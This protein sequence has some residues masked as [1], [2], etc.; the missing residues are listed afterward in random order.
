MEGDVLM[1]DREALRVGLVGCGFHGSAL[2]QAIVRTDLLRL[3]ACAD[4]DEAAAGRAAA[5]APEVST[6]NSV[7]ALLAE[8]D[9]DAVVVA[10]PHHLLAPVALAALSAGKHVLA[11]KPMALSEPEAVQIEIAAAN[12][13]VCYMAGYSFRFSMASYVRDLLAA[14]VAGEI[15]AITGS[16]GMGPMNHG[17]VALPETGGGPLFY[18]GCHLI[19][20]ILWFLADEPV[21]LYADV[22]R[23]AD[24]GT[25]ETSAI[26]IRF[27]NGAIAQCLVTQAASTFSYELEIHGRTGKIALRGRNFLQF[28]IEVSSNTVQA[29]REPTTIHPGVR[30]DNISMMLV[31][32]LEEFARSIQERRPPAITA[33]DGRRVLQVLDAVVESGRSGRP[34]TLSHPTSPAW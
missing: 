16:I 28:E 23:R 3:V 33:S 22:R 12:A 7:E 5:L 32:E 31:P 8:S 10:T 19:D 1:V 18:V 6:H 30:R 9:L 26:Q 14:G 29:Y 17:W 13:G 34:V 4:P 25:D 27:A 2:A 20:L 15:Q 21:G 11:E 24:T